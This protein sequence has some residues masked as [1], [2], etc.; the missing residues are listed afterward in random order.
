M[1]ESETC[2]VRTGRSSSSHH[3]MVNT[4]V[5]RG[6]TIL[7]SSL[8]E[9]ES[10]KLP[11]NPYASYGRF[12]TPTTRALETAIAELE[13]GHQA[14]VFPSGLAACTHSL[15]AFLKPGDHALITDSVYGPTRA[16]ALTVLRRFG[17]EVEFFDPLAGCDIRR[18]MRPTTRVVFVESPGSTTFEVQDIPAIAHEAHRVGAFV[19]MDNTWAS[20]LFFK[21]FEHGVDVSIQAATK[22][23]VGHSD[24]LLG[25]VT[26]NERAWPLL[27]QTAHDFGQTAGPDDLYLALRGLRSLSVRLHRHWEN[28]VLLAESM[29]RHPMVAQ[30]LHPALQDDPGHALWR[31][32]FKGASGLFAVALQPVGR[33]ALGIFFDSLELFGIGLSWGG[34]ESLALPMDP[35]TRAV[36][37]WTH[38]G[39]LLRIH[40]GLESCNDLMR[41]M[42]S[43]LDRMQRHC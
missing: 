42:Q 23:I 2:L 35:P 27:Q 12:G 24:A 26:A 28:G 8:S 4:P 9:W 1:F 18:Q 36:R 14:I 43:A 25:A 20:P 7:S 41:D 40:A 34:F 38:E 30:V 10:R 17:I 21:P 13:G 19:V 15:L 31:R 6:S 39:P 29:A 3:G 22:Y 33:A 5:F 11:G 37:P 16:F 32:D